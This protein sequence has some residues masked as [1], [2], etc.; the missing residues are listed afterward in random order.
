MAMGEEEPGEGSDEDVYEAECTVG[1]VVQCGV[2][3]Y[4]VGWE[5]SGPEEDTMELVASL[6]NCGRG[7]G[8]TCRPRPPSRPPVAGPSNPHQR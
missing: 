8:L 5:G 2:P 3:W 4:M 1:K 7:G 6:A